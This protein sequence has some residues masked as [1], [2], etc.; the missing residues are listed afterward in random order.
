MMLMNEPPAVVSTL[1]LPTAESTGDELFRMGLLYSTG[2]GGAPL[3]YV[4]AHMLFNL[5]AMRGSIEAK[6]YRKELSQEMASED[7]AEA[8]RQA[9]EWLA[10][11]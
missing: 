5:A 3:D 6:V 8:Q 9:R 10:H 2:Q 11:G 4:S 1:P 7:V